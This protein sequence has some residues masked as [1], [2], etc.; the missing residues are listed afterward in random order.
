MATVTVGPSGVTIAQMGD[1]PMIDG[2]P[3]PK[4][5][6]TGILASRPGS[7]PVGFVYTALDDP[8]GV[9]AKVWTGSSW[10]PIAPAV[11]AASGFMLAS[12]E[13]LAIANFTT[14]AGVVTVP[15]ELATGSFIMPSRP[16]F[17]QTGGILATGPGAGNNG[18][19][20]IAVSKFTGTWGAWQVLSTVAY[21]LNGGIITPGAFPASPVPYAAASPLVVAGNTVK[22]GVYLKTT[23]SVTATIPIINGTNNPYLHVF[24]R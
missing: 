6:D 11:G 19:F 2:P 7:P 9:Q 16:V 23:T 15:P 13:P 21:T 1:L 8:M 22:V 12:A 20:G 24:Q 4:M 18:S 10:E 3:G 17:A 14:G 5:G